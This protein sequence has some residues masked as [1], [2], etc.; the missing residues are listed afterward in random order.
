MHLLH[1]W[2]VHLACGRVR[3]HVQVRYSCV[4]MGVDVYVLFHAFSSFLFCFIKA[5]L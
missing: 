3:V 5:E 2:S 4:C 1:E